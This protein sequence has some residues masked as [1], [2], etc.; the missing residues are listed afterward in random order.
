MLTWVGHRTSAASVLTYRDGSV[1]ATGGDGDCG[2]VLVR[3]RADGNLDRGFGSNGLVHLRPGACAAARI[4][5]VGSDGTI[6]AAGGGQSSFVLAR[7]NRYG[8]P[9]AGFGAGGMVT[10]SVSAGYSEVTALR[11]EADGSEFAAGRTDDGRIALARFTREG[12]LDPDYGGGVV[13]L[14]PFGGGGGNSVTSVVL[15]RDGTVVAAGQIGDDIGLMRLHPDGTVDSTFGKDGVVTIDLGASDRA[16]AV[17]VAG[18]G[19]LVVVGTSGSCVSDND[20]DTCGYQWIALR[21]LKNGTLD[22]S[23]SGDGKRTLGNPGGSPAAVALGPHGSIAIGGGSCRPAKGGGCITVLRLVLLESNGSY[24]GR[25]VGRP[26]VATRPG[27]LETD[28][29][30]KGWNQSGDADALAW[31]SKNRIVAAGGAGG[32]FALARYRL[33]DQASA[34]QRP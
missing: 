14:R 17:T 34:S 7:V 13:L 30:G 28:F 11:V 2:F 1:L 21:L 16:A 4:A 31:D 29:I 23:F 24:D 33:I 25:L 12:Q 19:K 22:R 10:T 6:V 9:D 8:R 20:P 26:A 15:A 18:S 27:I 5:V 32:R 3:Y